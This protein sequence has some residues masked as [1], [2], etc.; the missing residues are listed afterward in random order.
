MINFLHNRIAYDDGSTK[1]K[2]KVEDNLYNVGGKV[3]QELI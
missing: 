1:R 3:L 2:K